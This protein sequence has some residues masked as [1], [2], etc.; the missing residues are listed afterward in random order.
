MP[1]T[2]FPLSKT[3]VKVSA[4]S[5]WKLMKFSCGAE[6]FAVLIVYRLDKQ[7]FWSYLAQDKGTDTMVV[8][9]YEYHSTHPGWHMHSNCETSKNVAGRTGGL[10][11]RFP[12]NKKA[13]RRLAF[14]VTGDES[15]E[16]RAIAAFGLDRVKGELL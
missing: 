1:K 13:H 16:A 12:R 9:R 15:A 4:A 11:D 8:A 5:R 14:A 3:K 7:Q 10:F 6:D 2:V